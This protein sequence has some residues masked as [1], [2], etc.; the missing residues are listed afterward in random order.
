MLKSRTLH[1][2]QLIT[3]HLQQRA[4]KH[5]YFFYN[6]FPSESGLTVGCSWRNHLVLPADPTS[7]RTVCISPPQYPFSFF[8]SVG[9]QHKLWRSDQHS[10]SGFTLHQTLMIFFALLI[11]IN[12]HKRLGHYILTS[13][14][15]SAEQQQLA[16][17]P[18]CCKVKVDGFPPQ[19]WQARST[20]RLM[21]CHPELSSSPYPTSL[22]QPFTTYSWPT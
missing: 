12:S 19:L 18:P 8:I 17:W 15:Q 3:E 22:S 13:Y 4:A 7:T 5:S 21:S 20:N 2:W 14:H 11:W 16:V 10:G 6:D 9:K 1:H